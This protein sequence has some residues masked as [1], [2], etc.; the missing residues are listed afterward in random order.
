MLLAK[1]W[2]GPSSEGSK[3]QAATDAKQEKP[4]ASKT[5]ATATDEPPEVTPQAAGGSKEGK[6]RKA[7]EIA[8]AVE[9]PPKNGSGAKKA[10]VEKAVE[11]PADESAPIAG[12]NDDAADEA[13]GKPKA[14]GLS[15]KARRRQH[16]RNMHCK[17][18]S[19]GLEYLT[20]WSAAKEA[21]AAGKKVKGDAAWKF[22]KATQAWL[23]RHLYEPE[24][25]PKDCFKLLL[26]YIDGLKGV[27]RDRL[28]EKANAVILV[29]G[30]PLADPE[31]ED[32][33]A[34]KG[35]K[36]KPAADDKAPDGEQEPA[37]DENAEANDEEAAAAEDAARKLRLKRAK[38]VVAALG[39]EEEED[40]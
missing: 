8:E 22:N 34:K 7:A 26:R 20:R 14:K 36:G 31:D 3:K 37:A 38:K 15:R 39:G 11:P 12:K 21:E 1:R 27:A 13:S 10:K 9:K 5:A 24:K 30:A 25:V 29:G 19:E 16:Q 17:E 6:R 40:A 33:K 35:K 18:A 32:P 4:D 28:R 23:L 2:T